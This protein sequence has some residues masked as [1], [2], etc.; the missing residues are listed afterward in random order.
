MLCGMRW[1]DAPTAPRSVPICCCAAPSI[2]IGVAGCS[3]ARPATGSSRRPA[4]PRSRA[5]SCTA[6][7]TRLMPAFQL[8]RR[9]PPRASA[10]FELSRYLGLHAEDRV[11]LAAQAAMRFDG[12]LLLTTGLS[13]IVEIDGGVVWRP[14]PARKS[15]AR[16][17]PIG[18]STP[19]PKSGKRRCVVVMR[20]RGE[21]DY[22]TAV[23]KHEAEAVPII[24][25]RV[26]RGSIVHADEARA[27]DDLH[28]SFEMKRINHR[29]AYSKDGACTNQAESYISS[30]ATRRRLGSAS[31]YRRASSRPVCRR[32]GVARRHAPRRHRNP[33]PCMWRCAWHWAIPAVTCVGGILAAASPE[34]GSSSKPPD[35][36]S[37][38]GRRGRRHPT[39]PVHVC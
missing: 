6:L 36:R 28:A 22:V 32:N 21:P 11:R 35:R 23:V 27:W 33:I 16:S 4:D 10:V 17:R 14:R 39:R 34:G 30:I 2:P 15:S 37:A 26:A 8:V 13:G 19:T 29:D 31:P 25:R 5:E 18:A 20:Q 24:R 9:P 1:P 3:N 38:R 7:R 12:E